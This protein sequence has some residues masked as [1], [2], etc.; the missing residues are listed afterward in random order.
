MSFFTTYSLPSYGG[1]WILTKQDSE[2]ELVENMQNLHIKIKNQKKIDFLQK[3]NF[4]ILVNYFQHLRSWRV[5]AI[6]L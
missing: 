6:R 2:T 3:K 5:G 1:F 4:F